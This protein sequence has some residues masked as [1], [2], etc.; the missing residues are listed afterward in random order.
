MTKVC[1]L[2]LMKLWDLVT[3][4]GELYN[5][6]ELRRELESLGHVYKSQSDAET[7]IHAYE[8]R[9]ENGSMVCSPL[10]CGM[11]EREIRETRSDLEQ[12]LGGCFPAKLPGDFTPHFALADTRLWLGGMSNACGDR[13]ATGESLEVRAPLQDPE[14]VAFAQHIPFR[15]KSRNQD[16]KWILKEAFSDLLTET[17]RNGGLFNRHYIR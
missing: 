11:D 16:R 14:L 17:I 7:I 8:E 12:P 9:G 3:Y 10:Q 2:G 1:R 5:H 4:N 15:Y 6:L 13:V